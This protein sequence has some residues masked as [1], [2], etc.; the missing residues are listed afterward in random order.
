MKFEINE[1]VLVYQGPLLYD[2]K[3]SRTF[4]PL[5]QK[6]TFYDEKKKEYIKASPDKKFPD[7]FLSETVYKVHYNGWNVKWDEWVDTS[8]I[9]EDNKE[10]RTLKEELEFEVQEQARLKQEEIERQERDKELERERLKLSKMKTKND[11]KTKGKSARSNDDTDVKDGINGVGKHLNGAISLKRSKRKSGSVDPNGNEEIDMNGDSVAKGK[12][13]K[14]NDI[15]LSTY[16]DPRNGFTHSEIQNLVPDELKILL[17]DDWEM[18]TKNNKLVVIPAKH[19]VKSVLDDFNEYLV[20]EFNDDR[21]ELSILHEIT[22]SIRQYF[23]QC[24]GTFVLYRYERPQHNDLISKQNVNFSEI[25]GAI[26]LLRLLSIFPSILML[27]NVDS[28]VIKITK[29]YLDIVLHWLNFNKKK[30][31]EVEYENQSPWI[32]VMHG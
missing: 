3:I 25:Y 23:D 26:F 27:N 14:G 17:V 5:T 16:Y 9:L 12:R 7:K 1:K 29:A 15:S 2:A 6:I 31:L 20:E 13:K 18:I 28:S 21:S 24:V 19:T 30:Y 11:H 10:N 32:S 22:E 4:D 8:R